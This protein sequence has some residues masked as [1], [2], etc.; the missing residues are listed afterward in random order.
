MQD[1]QQDHADELYQYGLQLAAGIQEEVDK[2]GRRITTYHTGPILWGE[3]GTNGQHAYF[4]MLHQGTA[5]VPVEFVAVGL[6]EGCEISSHSARFAGG[7][8]M[9]VSTQ[10]HTHHTMSYV[11]LRVTSPSAFLFAMHS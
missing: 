3:P 9:S 8:Y 2:H 7:L 5:V 11:F 10:P 4:Q 6:S 1:F